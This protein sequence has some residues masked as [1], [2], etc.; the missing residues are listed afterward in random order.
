MNPLERVALYAV[1]IQTGLRSAELRSVTKSGLLLAGEKPYV[2]C[3]AENTKNS[4]DPRTRFSCQTGNGL[5]AP[6]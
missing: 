6:S 4:S 1:A 5:P 2:R 3:R